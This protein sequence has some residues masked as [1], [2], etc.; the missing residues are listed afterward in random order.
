MEI[1]TTESGTQIKEA[2]GGGEGPSSTPEFRQAV[3]EGLLEVVQGQ[4]AG[5]GG[6]EIRSVPWGQWHIGHDR[7]SVLFN[8][9]LT[10]P[11][12]PYQ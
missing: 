2:L 4:L 11:L 6:W 3:E 10:P 7:G 9:P 8:S 5:G 12:P 1:S